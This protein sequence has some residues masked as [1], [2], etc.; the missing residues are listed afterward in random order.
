MKKKIII[1]GKSIKDIATFYEEINRVLMSEE[2]W[3][4]GNSLDAFNDLLYGGFGGIH[5]DEPITLVWLDLNESREALGYQVT[6]F[7]YEE[8]L[9]PDSPFNKKMF[10]EK[11]AALEYGTGETYFE[12]IVSIIYA[13]ENIEL[14][15]R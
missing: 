4:I 5:G 15:L 8:K 13:H 2:D 10:K 6:R 12:I 11:L 14:D 3:N 1:N 9:K 7:Y